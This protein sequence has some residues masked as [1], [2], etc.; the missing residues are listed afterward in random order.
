M[1]VWRPVNNIEGKLG[2]YNTN[3]SEKLSLSTTEIGFMFLTKKLYCQ[4]EPTSSSTKMIQNL[5]NQSEDYNGHVELFCSDTFVMRKNLM[6]LEQ[7][8]VQYGLGGK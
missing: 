8:H 2:S 7:K 3:R 4:S 6:L 1:D 5:S